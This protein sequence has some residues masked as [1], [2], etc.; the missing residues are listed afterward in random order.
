MYHSWLVSHRF[1]ID[2]WG[3]LTTIFGHTPMAA[4]GPVVLKHWDHANQGSNEDLLHLWMTVVKDIALMMDKATQQQLELQ[5]VASPET[6][7]CLGIATWFGQV[8]D[9]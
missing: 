9:P 7:L 6:D 1:P 4:Y 5:H 2:I 3:W 8:L